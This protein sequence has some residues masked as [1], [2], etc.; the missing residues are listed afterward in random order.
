MSALLK[1]PPTTDWRLVMRMGFPTAGMKSHMFSPSRSVVLPF[2][3]SGARNRDAT[4]SC[5]FFTV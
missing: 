1:T 2:S 5:P 3:L 4:L